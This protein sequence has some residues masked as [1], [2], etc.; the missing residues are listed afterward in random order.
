MRQNHKE[1]PWTTSA[2][3]VVDAMYEEHVKKSGK[4]SSDSEQ[5]F[6]RMVWQSLIDKLLVMLKEWK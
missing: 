6:R 4:H 2:E 1:D 3:I 5:E